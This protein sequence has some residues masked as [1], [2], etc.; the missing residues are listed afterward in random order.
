MYSCSARVVCLPA[1]AETQYI[2]GQ[3]GLR[4][5]REDSSLYSR[6]PQLP[7]VLAHHAQTASDSPRP[8]GKRREFE[9]AGWLRAAD[10]G[11]SVPSGVPP[12]PEV[13]LT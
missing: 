2:M 11:G 9:V 3:H 1:R 5:D 13:S 8:A 10:A 6:G 4:E 12:F 7:W